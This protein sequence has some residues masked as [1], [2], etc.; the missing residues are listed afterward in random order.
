MKTILKL[1]SIP[2]SKKLIIDSP[3]VIPKNCIH[4]GVDERVDDTYQ[5]IMINF[6]S[7]N[8]SILIYFNYATNP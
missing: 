4:V 1:N 6:N 2:T 3:T 5:N 7:E 8:F